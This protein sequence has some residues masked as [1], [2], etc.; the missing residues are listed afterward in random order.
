RPAEEEGEPV[1]L[2]PVLQGGHPET[3][4]DAEAGPWGDRRQGPVG[5]GQVR[6]VDAAVAEAEAG[7]VP[8]RGR[9]ARRAVPAHP[10][11]LVSAEAAPT[12]EH[13]HL[14]E[15]QFRRVDEEELYHGPA[16]TGEE[17]LGPNRWGRAHRSGESTS[18]L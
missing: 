17:P 13:Q 9:L 2:G 11:G 4:E 12:L 5:P 18:E 3:E 10:P 14:G 8:R 1:G 7:A 6:G 16:P 15:A